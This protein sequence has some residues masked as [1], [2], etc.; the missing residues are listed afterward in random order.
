MTTVATLIA[1]LGAAFT[2]VILLMQ[3]TPTPA[4]DTVLN[5]LLVIALPTSALGLGVTPLVVRYRRQ[6]PPRGVTYFA[7]IVNG[8]PWG[9]MLL[10][11]AF[12]I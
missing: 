4:T 9:I 11:R 10:S 12:H 6:P 1:C 8:L 3:T 7:F 5:I 2:K